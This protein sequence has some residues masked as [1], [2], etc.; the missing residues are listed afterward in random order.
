MRP[1]L[2]IPGFLSIFIAWIGLCGS[3]MAQDMTYQPVNTGQHIDANGVD[4]TDLIHAGDVFY[5]GKDGNVAII[6]DLLRQLTDHRDRW[7]NSSREEYLTRNFAS[8]PLFSVDQEFPVEV[9]V[10]EFSANDG[11]VSVVFSVGYSRWHHYYM[12]LK[13]Y[14]INRSPEVDRMFG[15]DQ[16]VKKYTLT[17]QD[18]GYGSS[19]Q[20]LI[21]TLG[22]NFLEYPG[23]SIQ[24]RTLYF[25][26][27]DL[28]VILQDGM[29]K[30]LENGKP[31]WVNG[32]AVVQ[33]DS[34]C[35]VV[36]NYEL[37]TVV[38][39]PDLGFV[40]TDSTG[41]YLFEVYPY[42]NGPDYP[43]EGLIRIREHGKIGF[44][45]M[46]G[47]IVIPPRYDCAYPFS[48]GTAIICE[49]GTVEQVGEH[50]E[51]KAARWGAIDP[52]GKTIVDP[53]DLG[54]LT[55]D[56]LDLKLRLYRT[57]TGSVEAGTRWGK[58]DELDIFLKGDGEGLF[59]DLISTSS[60]KQLLTYL[61]LP[62]QDLTFRPLP[63]E[64]AMIQAE[65]LVT[66]TPK[67]IIYLVDM[68]P[69]LSEGE[70]D[71]ITDLAN[72]M[73]DLLQVD[74][75]RQLIREEDGVSSSAGLRI[76]SMKEYP[77]Y[78]EVSVADPGTSPISADNVRNEFPRKMIL[79]H[80]VPET[81]TVRSSWVKHG[82]PE[83][84]VIPEV[85]DA[86]PDEEQNEN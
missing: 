39:I 17:Y 51:W 66:V 8:D 71:K 6:P 67:A 42:D 73:G 69:M 29:V 58:L 84:F 37:F 45:D 19:F 53:V 38:Y 55:F 4:V 26:G 11:W 23:Q 56:I 70:M 2:G 27:A 59:V 46:Q 50:A 68:T 14:R 65:Q 13:D 10:R 12:L 28:E 48:D 34:A 21:H 80:Q 85:E 62:W 30:Y 77:C 16:L 1:T 76:I 81:G 25:P 78:L 63:Q 74:K 60:G 36:F 52:T 64:D 41:R 22:L 9:L 32:P 3:A 83:S 47:K 44:A 5:P 75:N 86:A 20:D 49:E 31:E 15:L 82:P 57:F 72:L 54:L 7:I 79:L 24:L 61:Y 43:S 18:I 35:E 33:S 40:A